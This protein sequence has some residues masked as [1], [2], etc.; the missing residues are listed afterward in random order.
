MNRFHAMSR[1]CRQ[2][3][4]FVFSSIWW[5]PP[6]SFLSSSEWLDHAEGASTGFLRHMEAYLKDMGMTDL[7]SVWALARR[8]PIRRIRA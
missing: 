3:R 1:Q 8:R 2:S 6:D 5:I 4:K 7:A